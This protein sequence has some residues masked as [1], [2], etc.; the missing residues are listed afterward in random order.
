MNDKVEYDIKTPYI[1]S[2]GG[3]IKIPFGLVASDIKIINYADMEFTGGFDS[4]FRIERN[5]Q[6]EDLFTTVVNLS[7]GAEFE[8]PQSPFRLRVGGMYLPSPYSGDP[9]DFDKKFITAGAGFTLG[10]PVS[11]NIGYAYGWWKDFTD[12]YDSNVSR[13]Q[14]E[15]SNHQLILTISTSL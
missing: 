14:Q 8:I 13:I 10:E 9:T 15:I 2:F 3:A 4:G 7:I 12:N 11:I 1:Y 5:K 6:I